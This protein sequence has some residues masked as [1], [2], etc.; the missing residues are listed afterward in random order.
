MAKK[1]PP[2][3]K[4]YCKISAVA[5]PNDHIFVNEQEEHDY[6]VSEKFYI[7]SYFY[8]IPIMIIVFLFWIIIVFWQSAIQK[9]IE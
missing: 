9:I 6:F 5:L 1:L 2:V 8:M 3:N 7:E 4:A